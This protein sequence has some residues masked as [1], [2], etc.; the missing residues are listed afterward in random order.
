MHK[1]WITKQSLRKLL[2]AQIFSLSLLLTGLLSFFSMFSFRT[3]LI[4][5][6]GKAR[7]DVLKQIGERIETIHNSAETL[8]NL[9]YYDETLGNA[10]HKFNIKTDSGKELRECLLHLE[11]QYRN[12]FESDDFEYFVAIDLKKGFQYLSDSGNGY[13]F[14]IPE[15]KIWYSDVLEAN[16]EVWWSKTYRRKTGEGSDSVLA[17]ART[18]SDQV[19]GEQ[20]GTLFIVVPEQVLSKTY[21]N[22]LSDHNNIY[23]LNEDGAI[24]SHRDKKMVGINFYNMHRFEELFGPDSY[25]IVKKSQKDMFLI[26][27][28]NRN[29][30]YTIV[31]ETPFEIIMSPLRNVY[32]TI[33]C[34]F[35]GCI[36]VAFFLSMWL[37]KNVVHPLNIL[38]ESMQNMQDGDLEIKCDATGCLEVKQLS[39]GFNGMMDTTKQLLEDVESKQEQKRQTE[40]NFLQS[41]INPHFIYNTLFNIK[42]MAAMNRMSDV[43]DMITAFGKLLE[44]TLNTSCEM[45]LLSDEIKALSEYI[46]LLKYRYSN[47]IDII[48]NISDESYA[49]RIPKLTLQPI[50]ENA[51]FHGIEPRNEEG[52]II[53]NSW[54]EASLLIIEVIDDGVG[55]KPE[56]AEKILDGTGAIEGRGHYIGLR[57]INERIKIY[58]GEEYGI[59]VKSKEGIG[60]T[61]IIR[62][63][64]KEKNV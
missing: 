42:C 13:D 36:L 46:H 26:N 6:L 48:Y 54:V 45:L 63:P 61:V 2:F 57:N 11:D 19:T 5:E 24:L 38:C 30:K 23:I 40:L 55:M 34:I 25:A 39:D 4:R 47:Q 60:T 32:R 22:V 56:T 27:S 20:M 18:I 43:E 37:S 53:I 58:Y 9:Y 3:L 8:S 64:G 16:G 52:T 35:G 31:E 50:V 33:V 44:N 10:L 21:T 29:L 14:T 15:R 51:I 28:Y 59:K 41:Q 7:V 49:C 17:A 12:S 1:Q 62:I